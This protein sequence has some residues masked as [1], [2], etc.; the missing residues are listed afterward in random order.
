MEQYLIWFGM[1]FVG[2]LMLE[3]LAIDIFRYYIAE[4][5]EMPAWS[6]EVSE[7]MFNEDNLQN[8]NRFTRVMCGFCI[9]TRKKYISAFLLLHW[10][11]RVFVLGVIAY[12]LQKLHK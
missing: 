5:I 3:R 6:H 9:F 2:H 4:K 12:A 7:Y 10:L 8:E 1:L 11:S